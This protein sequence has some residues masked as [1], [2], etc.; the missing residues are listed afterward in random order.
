MRKTIKLINTFHNTE[1]TV[2]PTERK[3]LGMKVYDLTARQA[4]RA[5]KK[6][7]GSPDCTC[8][9]VLGERGSNIAD[10]VEYND[11]SVSFILLAEVEV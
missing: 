11:G 1:V 5:R 7:C 4:K 10:A 9:G 3:D 2:K 8:S 6:L